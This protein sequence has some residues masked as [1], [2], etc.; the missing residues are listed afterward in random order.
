M[1]AAVFSFFFLNV[2]HISTII[3]QIES[4]DSSDTEHYHLI[5]S[6]D[7]LQLFVFSFKNGSLARERIQKECADGS[8]DIFSELLNM[9]PQGNFGNVGKSVSVKEIKIRFG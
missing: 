5:P 6:Y 2:L 3:Y 9:T 4:K 8:W 7:W 1:L